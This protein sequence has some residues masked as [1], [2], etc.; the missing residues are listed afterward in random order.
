[1]VTVHLIKVA[2]KH[3][4]RLHLAGSVFAVRWDEG[5]R[6]IEVKGACGFLNPIHRSGPDFHHDG[7]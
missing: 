1:V 2:R 3:I 7:R 4:D 5:V 6:A